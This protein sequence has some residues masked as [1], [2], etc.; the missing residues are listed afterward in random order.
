MA[1]AFPDLFKFLENLQDNF[2]HQMVLEPNYKKNILDLIITNDTNRIFSVNNGPPLGS[3]E[4]NILH[5]TLNWDFLISNQNILSNSKDVE[6]KRQYNFA[7]CNFNKLSE[8][9]NSFNWLSE[10][11][12]MEIDGI[13]ERFIQYIIWVLNNCAEIW[14]T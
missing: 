11:K 10:F 5:S 1:N 13:N 7:K 4:K 14:F 8:L 6:H 12:N 3:T 9:F 2:L